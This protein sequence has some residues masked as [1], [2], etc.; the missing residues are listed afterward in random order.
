M[1]LLPQDRAFDTGEIR[2]CDGV[3]IE[4]K[5]ED[6]TEVVAEV[7]Y[8]SSFWMDR[9][10]GCVPF[11]TGMRL[12]FNKTTADDKWT[13]KEPKGLPWFILDPAKGT[14]EHYR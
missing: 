9:S 4:I 8:V 6:E 14:F 12:V 11:E 13:I 1:T 3:T 5:S 7:T 2:S 10:A